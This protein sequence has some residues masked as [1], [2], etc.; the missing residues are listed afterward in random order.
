MLLPE[1]SGR[2]HVD[3]GDAPGRANGGE[4]MLTLTTC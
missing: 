4:Q 3:P 2:I 1:S